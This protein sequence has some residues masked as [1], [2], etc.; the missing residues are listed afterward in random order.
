MLET[1]SPKAG[2]CRRPWRYWKYGSNSTSWASRSLVGS[3]AMKTFVE[4]RALS[5]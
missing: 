2:L 5:L 4:S 3:A 1:V